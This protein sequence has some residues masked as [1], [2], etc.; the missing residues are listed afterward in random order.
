VSESELYDPSF[1]FL[2]CIHCGYSGK[3][4]GEEID[5]S[6]EYETEHPR[7]GIAPEHPDYL[8]TTNLRLLSEV[9][10]DASHAKLKEIAR[11]RSATQEKYRKEIY[12][13]KDLSHFLTET[14]R[15]STYA[16]INDAIDEC[17]RIVEVNRRIVREH[18]TDDL[19]RFATES[20]PFLSYIQQ[21]DSTSA[22]FAKAASSASHQASV[23]KL[24]Q[25]PFYDNGLI[26]DPSEHELGQK[27]SCA[28]CGVRVNLQLG[29]QTSAWL[30]KY[31]RVLMSL[32]ERANSTNLC[33]NSLATLTRKDLSWL[34]MNTRTR[35]DSTLPRGHDETRA[36]EPG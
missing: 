2:V 25:T 20:E 10:R 31:P 18:E 1:Y 34:S 8:H 9:A 24:L 12:R 33:T 5:L 36:G 15:K 14:K 21:T 30:P 23:N 19:G 6:C 32:H 17:L 29:T 22:K 28:E 35:S 13:L 27:Y 26:P 3:F 11:R 16:D 4:T 7:P